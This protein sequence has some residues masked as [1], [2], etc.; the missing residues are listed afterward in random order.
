MQ[1]P[2]K[3]GSASNS[4][5]SDCRRL[6]FKPS[7]VSLVNAEIA[8]EISKI[9]LSF[10]LSFTS[11]RKK[12]KKKKK[13]DKWKF[14]ELLKWTIEK[15]KKEKKKRNECDGNVLRTLSKSVRK[16]EQL[17]PRNREN[18]KGS[19][20]EFHLAEGLL[21]ELV[22]IQVQFSE[23]SEQREWFGKHGQFV[24]TKERKKKNRTEQN[25]VQPKTQL[26]NDS[27][28]SNLKMR[29]LRWTR[30]PISSES[31]VKPHPLKK[32]KRTKIL[33]A[34]RW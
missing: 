12:K 7:Q 32:R 6:L 22:I 25:R 1:S 8:L 18:L 31:S 4:G 13:R 28:K 33:M 27:R 34:L 19:L 5:Q 30:F 20:F 23:L 17:V 15:E 3:L 9:W 14:Q 29:T 11:L 24:V 16:T 21:C 10:K 26:E 2:L